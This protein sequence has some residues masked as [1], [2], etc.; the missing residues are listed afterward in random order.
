MLAKV[1]ISN[2]I[3]VPTQ[4][5]SQHIFSSN[6][7]SIFPTSIQVQRKSPYCKIHLTVELPSNLQ[8]EMTNLQGNGMLKGKYQEK[9]LTEFYKC[10]PSDESTQLKSYAHELIL[11][12]GSTSL[13][14]KIFSKLTHV[15]CHYRFQHSQVS[16]CHQ[17]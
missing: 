14:E 11:V 6:S 10:L 5:L 12:F 3:S 7:S 8:L 16:I 15:N 9:T 4:I 13:C 2:E 17:F 1:K